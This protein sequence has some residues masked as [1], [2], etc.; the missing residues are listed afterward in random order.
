MFVYPADVAEAAREAR[1]LGLRTT[2]DGVDWPSIR[3]RVVRRVD[4]IER[5]GRAYRKGPKSPNT[6]VFEGWGRFTGPQVDVGGDERRLPA[7]RSPRDRF[8]I[9]DRLAPGHPRHP[10]PGLRI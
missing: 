2:V 7:R 9:A 4:D 1:Q 10:G 5:R 3:D 6:T 8:V